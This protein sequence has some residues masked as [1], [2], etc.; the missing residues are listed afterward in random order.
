MLAA[1]STSSTPMR[2]DTALRRVETVSTPSANT[3]APSTRKWVRPTS[4]QPFIT[5]LRRARGVLGG[6]ARDH[7]CADQGH[8]QDDRG[9]LEGKQIL[10]QK[11]VAETG[12]GRHGNRF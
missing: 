4:N 5:G 11:R 6:A 10:A 7:H 2:I 9:E 1:F 12:R 8:Q 3:I